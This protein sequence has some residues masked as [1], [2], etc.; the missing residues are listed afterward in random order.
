MAKSLLL[1]ISVKRF[2]QKYKNP[3]YLFTDEEYI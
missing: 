1:M 2:K 3:F